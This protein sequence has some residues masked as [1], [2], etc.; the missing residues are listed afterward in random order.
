MVMKGTLAI[1]D[2]EGSLTDEEKF[3]LL[4]PPLPSWRL[5]GR[6][7]RMGR[8]KCESHTH[9]SSTANRASLWTAA[10]SKRNGCCRPTSRYT[11]KSN[12]KLFLGQLTI[13]SVAGWQLDP[14]GNTVSL[15]HMNVT[16]DNLVIS[17]I[18][19]GLTLRHVVQTQP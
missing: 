11:H 7:R 13:I 16:T 1:V 8:R 5:G 4:L 15:Q 18:E 6:I 10:C 2:T 14:S 9:H 17:D 3:I 12:T 19:S